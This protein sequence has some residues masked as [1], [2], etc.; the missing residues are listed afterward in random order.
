MGR[1]GVLVGL[2]LVLVSSA[3]ATMNVDTSANGKGCK[4][5]SLTLPTSLGRT[6]NLFGLRV[7]YLDSSPYPGVVVMN[8]VDMVRTS[9]SAGGVDTWA[10][11]NEIW[12]ALR[13][14]GYAAET[15]RVS[16]Y[17]TN[18]GNYSE[19]Y[20]Y[21]FNPNQP[22]GAAAPSAPSGLSATA[23]GP[24]SVAL[25]WTDTS[26]YET[27]F[28][29]EQAEGGAFSQIGST[30]ANVTTYAVSGL[31]ADTSY[32]YRVR[33]TNGVGPSSYSNTATATTAGLPP[34]APGGVSASVVDSSHITVSWADNSANESG[35]RVERSAGGGSYALA[36]TTAAGAVTFSDTVSP[37]SSYQYRV[38]G[39][40][41]V[42]SSGYSY[43]GSAVVTPAAPAPPFSFQ[44]LAAAGGDELK[45]AISLGGLVVVSL[46]GL[47]AA[48]WWVLH[49]VRSAA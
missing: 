45:R 27:G 21:A 11:G 28:L 38:Q 6:S 8:V 47:V 31:S 37:S 32:Q 48:V 2:L 26:G 22:P 46:V 49:R 43:T 3:S 41:N 4:V 40:N 12:T 25:S 16:V 29:V 5:V 39:F 42:G 18:G 36:G 23:G 35:F 9:T 34:S 33:A 15:F 44:N 20:F 17:T 7:H 10:F 19:N 13:N 1:L 30:G 14:A 24:S